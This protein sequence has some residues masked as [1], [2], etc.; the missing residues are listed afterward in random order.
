MNTSIRNKLVELQDEWRKLQQLAGSR[1]QRLESSYTLHRF[2]S[3]MKELERWVDDITD[4]MDKA[5]LPQNAEEGEAM[6][7]LHQERK[8]QFNNIQI[9]S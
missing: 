4:K 5:Q 7:Q 1:R 3:N 2:M 6:L 9:S 8:V